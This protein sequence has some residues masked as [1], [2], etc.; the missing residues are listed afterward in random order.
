L[1][2]ALALLAFGLIALPA[3]VYVVGQQ[4]VG[5]YADGIAGLYSAIA[6]ALKSG[7]LY[8]WILV[9]SPLLTVQLMRFWVRLKRSRTKVNPVTDSQSQ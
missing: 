4:V 5:E 7:N 1:L 6:A 9:L 3:L 8:A 2:I